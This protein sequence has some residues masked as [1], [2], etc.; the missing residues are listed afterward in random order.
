[1]LTDSVP[2]LEQENILMA[3]FDIISAIDL[4]FSGFKKT[5]PGRNRRLLYM[6]TGFQPA[7]YLFTAD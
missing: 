3:Q 7:V 2:L 5:V 4:L 1:M 6:D